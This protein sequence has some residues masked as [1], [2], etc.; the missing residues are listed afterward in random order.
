[1]TESEKAKQSILEVKNKKITASI[2][3]LQN[4]DLPVQ[5]K[6]ILTQAT[7]SLAQ[8]KIDVIQFSNIV[9]GINYE[10]F[11]DFSLD[12]FEAN[13]MKALLKAINWERL[14]AFESDLLELEGISEEQKK[15]ILEI[16]KKNF[17]K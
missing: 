5:I 14:Q 10:G 3:E 7:Q 6:N 16:A 15:K 2:N 12:I 13:E 1:M 4:L 11:K 17:V 9:R 8:N